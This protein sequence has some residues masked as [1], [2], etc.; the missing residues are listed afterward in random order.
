[1]YCPVG[2]FYYLYLYLYLYN[3]KKCIYTYI[4]RASVSTWLMC[5]YLPE[6]V[7]T[8]T[9]A[10]VITGRKLM[11]LYK[12]HPIYKVTSMKVLSCNKNLPAATIEEVLLYIFLL[13]FLLLCSALSCKRNDDSSL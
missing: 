1:M 3:L 7:S 8:G 10:L 9:Y 5:S 11:G 12:G 6:M 4:I 2:D 13:V